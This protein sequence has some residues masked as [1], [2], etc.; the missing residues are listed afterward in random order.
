[1]GPVTGVIEPRYLKAEQGRQE[2]MLR[3]HFLRQW[4]GLAEEALEDA[5]YDSQA[6]RGFAR[7]ITAV[8][9]SRRH[10]W[11]EWEF[12][13]ASMASDSTRCRWENTFDFT[14]GQGSMCGD[15]IQPH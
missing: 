6:L 2:R 1:M 8:T 7:E 10:R 15:E 9:R 4:W 11:I 13:A 14:R 3:V 12:H 5:P